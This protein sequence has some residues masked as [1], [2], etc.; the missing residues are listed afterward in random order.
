M[1]QSPTADREVLGFVEIEFVNGCGPREVS[2][3]EG[4]CDRLFPDGTMEWFGRFMYVW[5]K[6]PVEDCVKLLR[7]Q[8]AACKIE[9]TTVLWSRNPRHALAYVIAQKLSANSP[10]PIG[11]PRFWELFPIILPRSLRTRVYDPSH[12]ELKEDYLTER[13]RWRTPWA[14]KWVTFAFTFRTGLL[15]GLCCWAGL[16]GTARKALIAFVGLVLGERVVSVLRE[17]LTE[18]LGRLP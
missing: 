10:L 6:D 7:G 1:N 17:K 13:K 15:V 8:L 14:R 12:E 5:L 16:S 3:I 2:M 18:W 9:Y 4:V 11:F